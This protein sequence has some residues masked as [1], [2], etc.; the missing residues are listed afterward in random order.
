MNEEKQK[1]LESIADRLLE[2]AAEMNSLANEIY[3]LIGTGRIDDLANG[4]NSVNDKELPIPKKPSQVVVETNKE[5]T[6]DGFSV[7]FVIE[8]S[9]KAKQLSKECVEVTVSFLA[10]SYEFK[11]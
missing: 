10:K 11:E 7:G 5:L 8:D 6:I 4:G 2:K 1:Q 9:V 3:R